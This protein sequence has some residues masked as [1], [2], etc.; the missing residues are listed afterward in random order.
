[1]LN[2]SPL[3]TPFDVSDSATDHLAPALIPISSLPPPKMTSHRS[4]CSP[5]SPPTL[6]PLVSK[7]KNP[8]P[9]SSQQ[10]VP[11]PC[12]VHR[13]CPRSLAPFFLFSSLLLPSHP[14]QIVG[15]YLPRSSRARGHRVNR[16]WMDSIR[17]R[18]IL[19]VRGASSSESAR[20]SSF[21]TSLNDLIPLCLC[22]SHGLPEAAG[23]GVHVAG[24]LC[25]P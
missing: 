16:T 18:L 3:F 4:A 9:V 17:L 10:P 1:M 5:Q 19:E 8:N 21:P 23:H 11:Q 6:A 25:H 15:R 7:K 22:C 14:L 12:S 24:S 20:D 13:G 2:P